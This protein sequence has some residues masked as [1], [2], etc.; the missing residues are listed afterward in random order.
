MF[1]IIE[2]IKIL[3]NAGTD[4]EILSLILCFEILKNTLHLV[5]YSAMLNWKCL[6]PVVR[7]CWWVAMACV[8]VGRAVRYSVD[9]WPRLFCF[10][11]RKFYLWASHFFP[12][13]IGPEMTSCFF[14]G[15]DT[16]PSPGLL[17]SSSVIYY[18]PHPFLNC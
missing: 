6:R 8:F 1:D 11:H 7:V 9:S 3:I 17:C 16:A 10:C 12:I 5:G 15:L 18:T 2:F 4:F 13:F 14:R